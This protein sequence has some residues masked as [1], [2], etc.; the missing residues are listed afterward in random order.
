MKRSLVALASLQVAA[1]LAATSRQVPSTASPLQR[2]FL[3]PPWAKS[4]NIQSMAAGD[5]INIKPI[6]TQEMLAGTQPTL[7]NWRPGRQ[8]VQAWAPAAS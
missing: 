4:S 7:Q 6:L 1:A 5:E 3:K 2:E 8:Q